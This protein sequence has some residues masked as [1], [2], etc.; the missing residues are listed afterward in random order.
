M[1]LLSLYEKCPD[2][3]ILDRAIIAGE[4][5]LKS[6]QTPSAGQ[7]A[8]YNP[9]GKQKSTDRVWS[10]SFRYL[11]RLIQALLRDE[12]GGIFTGSAGGLCL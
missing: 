3:K 5:L 6:S 10:W 9:E 4:H 7:R 11:L 2:K 1:G 12:K 8:W